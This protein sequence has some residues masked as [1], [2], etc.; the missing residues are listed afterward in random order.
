VRVFAQ[1][2]VLVG[3]VPGQV[4][5]CTLRA[6]MRNGALLL[7]IPFAPVWALPV[8]DSHVNKRTAHIVLA[9][10]LQSVRPTQIK[11]TRRNV[12]PAI[13]AWCAVIKCA[14]RKGLPLATEENGAAVLWREYRR[15]AKQLWRKMR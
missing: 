3:A 10:S 2:P 4:F 1:N 7:H 11:I 9:G 14:G 12:D 8:D 6:D 13:A 5:R 15:A